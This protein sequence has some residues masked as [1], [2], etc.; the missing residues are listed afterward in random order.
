MTVRGKRRT[1]CLSMAFLR[2]A[3]LWLT[4]CVS[5]DSGPIGLSVLTLTSYAA[6]DDP[7][8]SQ[9]SRYAHTLGRAAQ[10]LFAAS[11]AHAILQAFDGYTAADQAI[12]GGWLKRKTLGRPIKYK[13]RSKWYGSEGV[14]G[15]LTE[16]GVSGQLVNCCLPMAYE[17]LWLQ[18]DNTLMAVSLLF[19]DQAN[20]RSALKG[21]LDV[22]NSLRGDASLPYQTARGNGCQP[23]Y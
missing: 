4:G 12:V 13:D 21:Y 19:N 6:R 3:A 11:V 10:F 18:V 7:A 8:L 9:K 22:I 5:D 1:P 15:A 14:K 16:I 20:F 23:R 2:G 17:S